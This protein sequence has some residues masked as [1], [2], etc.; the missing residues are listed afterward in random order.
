MNF[1]KKLF[2]KR[3]KDNVRNFILAT[4]ND[5]IMPLDRGEID[6]DPLEEFLKANGIG[7]VTGGGTM[8]LK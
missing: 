5:K 7:E 3:K 6:E 4:L 8:Q 2:G 1:I